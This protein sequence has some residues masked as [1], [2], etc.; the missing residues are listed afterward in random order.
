M[1]DMSGMGL[2]EWDPEGSQLS[3]EVDRELG[4]ED[5]RIR[6]SEAEARVRHA[7]GAAVVVEADDLI[8]HLQ[9]CIAAQIDAG[10][11]SDVL[12]QRPAG[13]P[14]ADRLIVQA[15]ASVDLVLD[16]LVVRGQVDGLVDLIAD[17][18]LD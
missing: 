9:N 4:R 15:G 18:G 5:R 12:L 16:A 11:E 10:S 3:L 2:I 6:G 17:A 7:E 13:G 8:G 14:S 1:P